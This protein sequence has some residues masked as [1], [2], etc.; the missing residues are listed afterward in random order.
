MDRSPG[1]SESDYSNS[2]C[3]PVGVL[4]VGVYLDGRIFCEGVG[5]E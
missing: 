2:V 5:F 3:E 4:A 1:G